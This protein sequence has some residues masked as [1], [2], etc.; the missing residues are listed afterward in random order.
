[1][2]VGTSQIEASCYHLKPHFHRIQEIYN[3]RVLNL[4]NFLFFQYWI[5]TASFLCVTKQVHG[6]ASALRDW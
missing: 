5:W 2:N 4:N 1:M 3:I 6:S